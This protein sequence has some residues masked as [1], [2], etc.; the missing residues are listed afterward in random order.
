MSISFSSYLFV[1]S[2][3]FHPCTR[4][5]HPAFRMAAMFGDSLILSMRLFVLPHDVDCT[6][7]VSA[8]RKARMSMIP[9]RSWR[10]FTKL[11]HLST[12]STRSQV[13]RRCARDSCVGDVFIFALMAL[14]S[15][16]FL[17][18]WQ[19]SDASLRLV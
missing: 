8:P 13:L 19:K 15:V 16:S 12:T 14:L 1:F 11:F 9:N 3:F 4:I 2:F 7:I 5:F 18:P 6:A 10:I 17:F